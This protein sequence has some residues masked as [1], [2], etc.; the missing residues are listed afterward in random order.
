[1]LL[2]V[3]WQIAMWW[4][5]HLLTLFWG[6]RFP[7]QAKAFT[8]SGRDRYLHIAA[9]L[10]GVCFPWLPIAIVFA[11]GGYRFGSFPPVLCF[12]SNGDALYYTTL[13]PSALLDAVGLCLLLVIFFTIFKVQYQ[14]ITVQS[15][16]VLV[17]MII[18]PVQALVN[19]IKNGPALTW[20]SICN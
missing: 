1:M 12:A 14:N 4:F 15:L 2:Y 5:L 9:I 16:T 17:S 3:Y 20:I 6:I 11:T 7:L 13:L 10:L 8:A 18:T 19:Q